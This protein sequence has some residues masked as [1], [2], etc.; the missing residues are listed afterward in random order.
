MIVQ[1]VI[2]QRHVPKRQ[3]RS[4]GTAYPMSVGGTEG[5]A[6]PSHRV[7]PPSLV[8][9]FIATKCRARLK[10]A[11][12]QT[13]QGDITGQ[14]VTMLNRSRADVRDCGCCISQVGMMMQRPTNAPK[15][16]VGGQIS[17]R[18]LKYELAR[19]SPNG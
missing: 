18:L 11:L 1:P 15:P 7:A 19:G 16:C 12:A 13:Q 17:G 9:E 4:V 2:A 5:S 3:R 6:V 8:E 14:N 10:I